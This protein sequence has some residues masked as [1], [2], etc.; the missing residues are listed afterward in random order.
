MPL[1]TLIY[2]STVLQGMFKNRDLFSHHTI[3]I[4]TPHF[5]V[6]CNGTG[7]RPAREV[8]KLSASY[9]KPTEEPELELICTAYNINPGRDEEVLQKCNVLRDYTQFVE[10]V[11]SYEQKEIENPLEEAI[12]YCIEHDILAD[13]LKQR[14]AEVLKAMTI[15]M[16]FER[17]EVLIREE[18]RIYG[19]EEGRKEGRE[20][21]RKEGRESAIVQF[22][23]N[24]LDHGMSQEEAISLSGITQELIEKHCK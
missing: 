21:G 22:Y 14:R 18:E 15:D 16:T 3:R 24:C 23:R 12:D 20:E 7:N 17:R 11:R 2:F 6:F 9:A 5:A 1:R 13:F 4:P 8:L 19:R 10:A